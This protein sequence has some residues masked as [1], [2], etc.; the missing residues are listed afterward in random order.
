MGVAWPW[1]MAFFLL[2]YGMPF[3]VPSFSVAAHLIEIGVMES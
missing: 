3:N 2:L 1:L